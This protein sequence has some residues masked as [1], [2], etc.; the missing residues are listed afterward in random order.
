MVVV[1]DGIER[2]YYPDF[3]VYEWNAYV[4]TKADYWYNKDREKFKILSEQ[5]DTK[6]II[7]NRKKLI[8]LGVKMK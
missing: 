6:I 4:D 2:S 5:C 3:Y 7:L 1:R 8:N